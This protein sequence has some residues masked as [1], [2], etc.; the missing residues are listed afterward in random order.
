M[1]IPPLMHTPLIYTPLSQ[2]CTTVELI[3]GGGGGGGTA[4]CTVPYMF[5]YGFS[6]H[7][8]WKNINATGSSS[9]DSTSTLSTPAIAPTAIDDVTHYDDNSATNNNDTHRYNH[10]L[11]PSSSSSSSLSSSHDDEA[12]DKHQSS[13]SD[14]RQRQYDH[15]LVGALLHDAAMS[16][17]CSSTG[18]P[19]LK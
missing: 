4:E 12:A 2:V 1:Y 5:G 16:N 11:P 6:M 10:F 17:E 19:P 3:G 7:G 9:T 13:D 8:T 15:D 18:R 14:Y